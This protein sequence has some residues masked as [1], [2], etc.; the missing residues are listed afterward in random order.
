MRC[1]AGCVVKQIIRRKTAK[2]GKTT[3]RM[4]MMVRTLRGLWLVPLLAIAAGCA[5]ARVQKS[6][7]PQ[8][9]LIERAKE[10]WEAR[11][12]GD[13]VETYRL[14]EPNFRKMVTL[15]AFNQGRGVT[16]VLDYEITSVRIRGT[17]GFVT[18]RVYHT[19]THPQLVKPV[20]PRWME[21]DEQWRLVD[22]EWYRRFRFPIGDPY[23]EQM[24]WDPPSAEAAGEPS[25]PASRGQ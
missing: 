13:L 6:A 14:H 17:K 9:R 1:S 2:G 21:A 19:I 16:T 23:P 8:A 15:T 22:G 4:E 24:Q 20:D 5:G 7:D 25:A 3:V 10:Y 18:V 12:K 11:V